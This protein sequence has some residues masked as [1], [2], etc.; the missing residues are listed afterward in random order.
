MLL[1]G[2]LIWLDC[3][4]LTAGTTAS[5]DPERAAPGWRCTPW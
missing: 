4:S 2:L 3:F 1:Y 5:V